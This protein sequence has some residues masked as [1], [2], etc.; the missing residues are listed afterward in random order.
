MI[1]NICRTFGHEMKKI[2]VIRNDKIGDF[3]LAWPAFAMLKKA[4]PDSEITA[5]VP[6]YTQ[7]LAEL[8]PSIDKVIVDCGKDADKQTKTLLVKD[9][10]SHRFDASI[11][12]FSDGYN[13][14]LVWRACIGFRLAPAT[15]LCQ[16]LYNHRIT[17]RRSKSI[18]PEFQ[19]NVD[20]ASAF[21][22]KWG[23]YATSPKGPYL[24]FS[25]G[26]LSEQKNT[27]AASLGIEQIKPWIFLHAGSGGSANNLSLEQ[28]RDL[29]VGI[30]ADR[31]VEVIL[32]AGPGETEK[33]AQLKGLLTDRA[34]KSVIYD[35]KDGLEAFS[36]T[37]ACADL[38]IAGSTGPL[39]I[40]GALDVPTV[41]FFPAKRSATPLRWKPINSEGR[42]LAFSPAIDQNKKEEEDMSRVQIDAI[43]PDVM[44]FLNRLVL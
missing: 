20:L 3:M 42:H 18:K 26:S 17:Q 22:T 41:G 36:K 10:K 38:F 14:C 11:C 43:L 15:K 33:A 25:S 7:A 40:A 4:M 28:Y 31:D 6:A 8:C 34:V 29:L 39:H 9:I 23:I 32:T 1:G 5:L 12:F 21:L 24:T 44:L 35:A 37:I 2:L 19:Y 13:A 16:F 27:L 30:C